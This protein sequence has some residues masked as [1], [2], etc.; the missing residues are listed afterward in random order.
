MNILNKIVWIMDDLAYVGENKE[1]AL[2]Q[3]SRI[4]KAIVD[5]NMIKI[6]TQ[7]TEFQKGEPIEV[8]ANLNATSANKY[9]GK[10]SD[11]A[12]QDW[13][14]IVT[15]EKFE[16]SDYY[17]LTGKWEEVDDDDEESTL[18]SWMAKIEKKN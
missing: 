13:N 3:I 10:W 5:E 4:E 17:L 14:G 6:I 12:D 15:C 8:V 11:Y 1:D 16:N 2:I 7:P 9:E 18:Y